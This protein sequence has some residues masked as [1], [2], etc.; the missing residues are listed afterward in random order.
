MKTVCINSVV[1]IETDQELD[2]REHGVRVP[3]VARFI[4]LHNVQTGSEA[5]PTSYPIGTGG[6]FKEAGA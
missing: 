2:S 5:C 6:S 3:I 1:G 4:L